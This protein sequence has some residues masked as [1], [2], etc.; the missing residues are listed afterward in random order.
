MEEQQTLYL[1]GT[2]KTP[3]E[4][5][6]RVRQI[7]EQT[8]EEKLT[9]KYLAILTKYVFDADKENT[10]KTKLIATD[11]RM[12]TVNKHETSFQ[13]MTSRI[14]NGNE[15]S[16][17]GKFIENDKNILITPKIRITQ[18]DLD[19]IP[20]LRELRAAIDKV[21][22]QA[23]A[24]VGKK[25]SL[26]IKQLIEMRKDQYV[27]KTSYKQPITCMNLT[28]SSSKI[29]FSEHITIGEDGL[30][31]SDGFISFFEPSHISALLCH[32]AR[33]KEDAYS[34]FTSDSYYM[35]HDLDDLVDKTL[36]EKYP[37]YYKLLIYKIDGKQNAEIQQLLY[38]EFGI[39]HS[40]EY[41]SSLWRKKIPKLIA[42]Q[43]TKD[44][45]M[46]YY[47]TQE[48]GYWKK[49]SCCGQIKL[50]HNLF[51]SKNKTSK[52]GL[53]SICKDCRNTKNKKKK[54]A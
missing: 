44:Y 9:P 6:E 53:Y 2:I 25:K 54:E 36:K 10:K 21:E 47:T 49:C 32:Y 28:K 3:E 30:P 50:G 17:Y 35:M 31:H 40:V 48:R 45:L 39:M 51:F 24:A 11:N 22:K 41:I 12:V 37:L 27:I 14:E 43:A 16:V 15:D 7:V 20:E 46:W 23:K 19:E 26:L 34:Q 8:P 42:E 4:R 5:M 1:D 38:D 13:G 52:D 29:D 33:I 18:Q